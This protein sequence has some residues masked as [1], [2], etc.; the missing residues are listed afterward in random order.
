MLLS[1]K[2]L[3]RFGKPIYC[4]I[5]GQEVTALQLESE[6]TKAGVSLK[7]KC[8]CMLGGQRLIFSVLRFEA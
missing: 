3:E 6:D 7:G 2:S 5:N 8:T 1:E 4:H